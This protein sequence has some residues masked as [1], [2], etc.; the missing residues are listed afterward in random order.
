MPSL[1]RCRIDPSRCC[2][3]T[4][5]GGSPCGDRSVGTVADR[6]YHGCH[7]LPAGE[8]SNAVVRDD[9]VDVRV[10]MWQRGAERFRARRASSDD[11]V[12]VSSLPLMIDRKDD[13]DVA[14]MRSHQIDREV[15]E[16]STAQRDGVF[17]AAE[18][19]A[20]A[21]RKDDG[22]HHRVERLIW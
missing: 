10:E 21:R 8:R 13:H 12:H 18:T 22:G 11:S 17:R 19:D 9:D 4:V 20:M 3:L 2:R 1:P 5:S 16:T 15:D 7:L 14:T 6:G